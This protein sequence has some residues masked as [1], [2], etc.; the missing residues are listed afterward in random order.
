MSGEF[1]ESLCELE[2]QQRL[3]QALVDALLATKS[4]NLTAHL[5]DCISKVKKGFT[6]PIPSVICPL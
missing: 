3:L 2:M 5:K 4:S 1:F 6:T